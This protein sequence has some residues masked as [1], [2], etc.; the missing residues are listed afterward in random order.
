MSQTGPR[1][2]RTIAFMNQKGGV[3]K[4]T[5]T[6]NLAAGIARLG[7]RVLL[8]DLDPQG[9]ATLHL[10]VNPGEPAVDAGTPAAPKHTVY[11]LLLNPALPAE[12][13]ITPVRENLWLMP[14]ETDLAAA[15]TELAHE[16][17]RL[18]RL[19]GA[20]RGMIARGFPAVSE[21]QAGGFDIVLFDCP[22]SLGMLTLNAL[23][24][25]REVFIPMQAHFLALQGVSK[26]LETVTLVGR[27]VNPRLAVTGV[28]LCMHDANTTH[29]KEVVADLDAFFEQARQT[30]VEPGQEPPAWRSA[31]V[32]RPAIRRNIKLAEC[33]SF[34]KTIFDYD[35]EC[36]GAK[37][38]LELATRIVTEWD[39]VIAKRAGAGNGE[40]GPAAPAPLEPVVKS[41]GA[42]PE[43]A[44]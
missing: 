38:Y 16:P 40:Q 36:P 23:C 4:T 30:P 12:E 5:T 24:A 26:L 8:I 18:T 21:G 25:A 9:H 28:I 13:C 32:Y 44:L 29:T 31:R 2:V 17:D 42:A 33:P 37:D 20:L 11:D 1:T 7:K 3:G 14:A 41:L 10:G 6:V 19:S 15:E 35:P 22:P 27:S 39:R 34:G 43:R